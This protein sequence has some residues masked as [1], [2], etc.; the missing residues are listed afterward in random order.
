[1]NGFVGG[2]GKI[3]YFVAQAYVFSELH[4]GLGYDTFFI[5]KAVI[6]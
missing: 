6:V 3:Q 4:R 1:V 5:K 2:F